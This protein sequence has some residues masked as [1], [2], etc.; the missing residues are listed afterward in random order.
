MTSLSVTE[1][2]ADRAAERAA[3]GLLAMIDMAINHPHPGIRANA[4]RRLNGYA[5]RAHGA[6][7]DVMRQRQY[8]A[9]FTSLSRALFPSVE[10]ERQT[11]GQVGTWTGD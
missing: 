11:Y 7:E 5:R 10:P 6:A 8:E 1:T 3:N 9:G 4:Y 2:H